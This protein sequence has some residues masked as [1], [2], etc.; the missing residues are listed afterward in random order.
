MDELNISGQE[1]PVTPEAPVTESPI[2]EQIKL[3]NRKRR[4]SPKQI[5]KE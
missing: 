4:K 5:F 3:P 1:L 2:P